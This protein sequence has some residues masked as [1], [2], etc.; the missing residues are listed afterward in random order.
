[1]ASRPC[2]IL[3][4]L[5]SL[6][7][8]VGCTA[9][10]G[11]GILASVNPPPGTPA[12]VPVSTISSVAPTNAN[13]GGAEFTITVTGESFVENSTVNWNG[14]RRATR[15]ITDTQLT[16]TITAADI[17]AAGAAQI[18]VI[19]RPP[20]GGTSNP[21]GFVINGPR[22]AATPGFVYVA[23]AIFVSLTT[24]SMAAFSVDPNTGIL[25]PVP[26]SPFQAGAEPAGMAA[27]PSGKFL[28]EVKHLA[29]L[30]SRSY[31]DNRWDESPTRH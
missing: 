4:T 28:Y 23:N 8:F 9:G 22:S 3:L 1:V 29:K 6:I 16:A 27:D 25:T 14:T 31:C 19:N 24:G 17:A 30:C 12:V 15:E 20:G 7:S 2:L 18:T 5:A 21:V 11:G 10:G 26:G 13:A